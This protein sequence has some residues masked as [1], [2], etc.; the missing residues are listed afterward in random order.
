M[1]Y[2]PKRAKIIKI[3]ENRC[4]IVQSHM[5][6]LK[7]RNSFSWPRHLVSSAYL[8]WRIAGLFSSP[9]WWAFFWGSV[10]AVVVCS[11]KVT[12]HQLNRRYRISQG[13]ML[14]WFSPAATA[15]KVEH[16]EMLKKKSTFSYNWVQESECSMFIH[17]I[18]I[19]PRYKQ[20]ILNTTK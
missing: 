17:A 8:L 20:T 7:S 2:S 9:V 5:T 3:E 4:H 12:G 10:S 18:K 19:R 11:T 15:L 16:L 1:N 13:V 6:L 14:K